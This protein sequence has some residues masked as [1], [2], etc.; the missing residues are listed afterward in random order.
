MLA[1]IAT[2]T[3]SSY[4][5]KYFTQTCIATGT[6]ANRECNSACTLIKTVPLNNN[7]ILLATP[8]N[9]GLNAHPIG[10]WYKQ[11]GSI[12]YWSVINQ[13]AKPMLDGSTFN[14]EYYAIPDPNFQF[15]H[16]VYQPGATQSIFTS[17][18]DHVNLNGNPKANFRYIANG[19]GTNLY[20][21]SFK[22]DV[23]VGKWYLSNDNHKALDLGAAYNIVIYSIN[24][25]GKSDIPLD[26]IHIKKK[27]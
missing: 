12:W 21:I 26:T 16:H 23:A 7:A 25:F 10:V 19:N 20:P 5:Q 13:D 18:I 14:V 3:P 11:V 22:Y 6:S 17:Y 2:T 15:V 24:A 4:A 8:I 1:L 27:P 9:A